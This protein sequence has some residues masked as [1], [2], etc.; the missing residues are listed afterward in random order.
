MLDSGKVPSLY[1][2]ESGQSF[3][4]G[5]VACAVPLVRPP[6]AKLGFFDGK[7]LCPSKYC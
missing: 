7:V 3:Y 5:V 2:I 4:W 1:G 6:F